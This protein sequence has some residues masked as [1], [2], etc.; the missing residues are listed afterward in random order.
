MAEISTKPYIIRAIYEWCS[1]SGLT[2]YLAVAVDSQTRVPMEFVKDGEIVLNLSVSATNNMTIGNDAI[3][4]SAR[5][6]GASRELYV[7]I[8]AVIGI[9]SRENGQ[10][11]FFP[12]EPEGVKEITEVVADI[13][14]QQKPA[15]KFE[16]NLPQKPA[17]KKSHLKLIK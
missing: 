13:D 10:G 3:Q 7:P 4:F 14:V 2:P 5:F 1:D 11:M 6:S 16:G 15:S 9:F 12:K 17:G 8:K